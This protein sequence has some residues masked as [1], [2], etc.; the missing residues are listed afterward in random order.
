M[1]VHK[2]TKYGAVSR[3]KTIEQPRSLEHFVN[4]EDGAMTIFATFMFLMMLMVAGI[5]VDLM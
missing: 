3:A 1:S 2:K 4:E 5:G